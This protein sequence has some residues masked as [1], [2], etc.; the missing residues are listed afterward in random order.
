MYFVNMCFSQSRTCRLLMCVLVSQ[1]FE[2]Y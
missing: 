1:E 2:D